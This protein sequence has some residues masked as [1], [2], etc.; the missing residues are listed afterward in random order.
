MLL[1]SGK[2]LSRYS[3]LFLFAADRLEHMEKVIKPALK[4]RKIVIS[5][6]FVDSTTAYQMGGRK[7][8]G[9]L[10]SMINN[11][12]S[13]GIMPDITILLDVPPKKGIRRGTRLTGKDR[14]E[15]EANSFHQ[16]VRRTYLSIAGKEKR[17]VRLVPSAGPIMDVQQRIRKIINEKL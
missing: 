12:S 13:E 5:D 1:K 9:S 10:V 14:F 3:E 17:R 4:A 2:L 15:S 8:P 16:R 11:I 6:R 7:L